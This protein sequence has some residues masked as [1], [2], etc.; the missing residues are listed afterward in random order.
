MLYLLS[1]LTDFGG[2]FFNLFQVFEYIT[3]RAG[4]A[5]VTSFCIV[6]FFGPR[7]VELLK[8][9]RATAACRY[10]GIIDEKFINRAKDSVPSMGGLLIVGAICVSAVLWMKLSNP[11][12]AVLL[13][14]IISFAI[15]GFLDDYIKVAKKKKDGVSK[16]FKIVWQGITALLALLF[17]RAL[18][19][20]LGVPID[21]FY[22][23]FIKEPVWVS[24]WT[25][26][27][28]VLAIVGAC[29]AVNLTDGLDGLATGSS[30]VAVSAYAV[31]AYL[32]GHMVFADYLFIPYIPA[33]GE[34]LVFSA[35]L[36]GSC[37]GFLWYNAPPASVFMGD[38]GSLAL[39]GSLG[40]LAVI[41]RHELLLI[42]IGGVLLWKLDQLYYKQLRLSIEKREY[43]CVRQFTITLSKRGGRNLK[44]L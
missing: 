44:S 25:M 9:L 24:P 12:A 36:V 8:T 1:G 13:I 21:D 41:V 33:A 11:V 38:T 16:K 40:M 17:L 22:V 10:E 35:A 20:E 19:V 28:D 5:A 37:A 2:E 6:I 34:A 42:I 7:V 14:S 32:S 15:L 4:A 29:N 31:I 30:I 43:F 3:F 18:P 39:G 26:A 27:I 23:P